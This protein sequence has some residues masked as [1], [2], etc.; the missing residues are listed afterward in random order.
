[1]AGIILVAII[2]ILAGCFV[3]FGHEL[4]A[5][6][7]LIIFDLFLIYDFYLQRKKLEEKLTKQREGK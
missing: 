5:L 4:G 3:W 7:L 1:M 6:T 2:N